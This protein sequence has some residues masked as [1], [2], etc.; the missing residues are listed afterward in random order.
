MKKKIFIFL[1]GVAYPTYYG[2]RV[3]V[4]TKWTI[5]DSIDLANHYQLVRSCRVHD[6]W[7]P[8]VQFCKDDHELF[9]IGEKVGSI[10]HIRQFLGDVEITVTRQ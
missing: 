3:R 1:N 6:Y 10:S 7:Y 2:Y 9:R 4:G 5:S 8:L